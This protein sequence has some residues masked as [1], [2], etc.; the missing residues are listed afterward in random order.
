VFSVK[1]RICK[2]E[3]NAKFTEKSAN[4]IFDGKREKTFKMVRE[5]ACKKRRNVVL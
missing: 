5:N 2:H 3:K 4:T 1:A